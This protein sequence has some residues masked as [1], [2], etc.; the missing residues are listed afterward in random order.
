MTTAT[1][2]ITAYTVLPIAPVVLAELRRLDDADNVP[3]RVHDTDGGSP[4]RC[5]LRGAEP[6]AHLLLL[7]YAPLRRWA[8][9][10]GAHPGPYDEVGPVFVHACPADCP[11]PT[12]SGYPA[13]MHRGDRVFR[14]Y[15]R[16]GHILRGVH[17][18]PGPGLADEVLTAMFSDPEV[19]VVHVRALGHGCFQHEV[20][21][22]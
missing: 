10:T 1:T 13:A 9:E 2:T 11:G 15:D 20:R 12:S 4:L 6:G 5:C 18:E 14:A 19:A 21:R 17:V 3:V 8:D 7:S 16:N 22:A